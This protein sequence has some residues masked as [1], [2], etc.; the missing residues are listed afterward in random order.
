MKRQD[1]PVAAMIHRLRFEIE[2]GDLTVGEI[3][4]IL[5]ESG[6]S[7]VIL[8]LCLPFLQPIPF[9][10]LSTPIGLLIAVS[11][12]CHAAG[13]AP[14]IP[15][16][17]RGRDVSSPLL[18]KVLEVAERAANRASPWIHP[19]WTLLCD[20]FPMRWANAVAIVLGAL[21]LALPLPVPFSNTVPAIAIILMCLGQLEKDGLFVLLS[22]TMVLLSFGFFAGIAFG[23]ESGMRLF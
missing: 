16:R 22:H 9:P 7:V 15:R 12:V 6:H 20:S 23:V 2:T 5:S 11:A 8:F 18:L 1:T 4:D 21:L 14:W 3:H 19:R 10:G 13:T 17:W